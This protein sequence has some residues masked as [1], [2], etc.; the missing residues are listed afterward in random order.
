MVRLTY[1]FRKFCKSSCQVCHYTQN[2]LGFNSQT[3]Q[4]KI[5]FHS[6][7]HT[8]GSVVMAMASAV[9][10]G[11]FQV[12][13]GPC[14][15]AAAW[16]WARHGPEAELASSWGTASQVHSPSWRWYVSLNVPRFSSMQ[17]YPLRLLCLTQHS[18]TAQ[19]VRSPT[20]STLPRH[21][22]CCWHWLRMHAIALRDSNAWHLRAPLS[23]SKHLETST[24]QGFESSPSQRRCL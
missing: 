1:S 6:R 23:S 14:T 7:E 17:G 12:S 2:F 20:D 8:L 5:K 11:W 4:D 22:L 9:G 10:S 16:W 19:R 18:C 15:E 3:F 13:I 21:S 24:A